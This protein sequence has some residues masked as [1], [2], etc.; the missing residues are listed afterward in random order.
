[1]VCNVTEEAL[2]VSPDRQ[3]ERVDDNII[4]GDAQFGGALDDL[5]GDCQAAFC[6]IGDAVIVHCQADD[7]RAMFLDQRQYRAQGLLLAVD[8]IDQ[9]LAGAQGQG[10]GQ[11]IRVGRIQAQGNIDIRSSAACTTC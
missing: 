10:S 5:L 11:C 4:S 7:S 8:R 1:M 9:G 6:I 2:L 3:H